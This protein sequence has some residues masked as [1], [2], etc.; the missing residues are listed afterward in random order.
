MAENFYRRFRRLREEC[1]D[2][3]GN[4][5]IVEE[6]H[7]YR[8]DIDIG[9]RRFAFQA[10]PQEDRVLVGEE[11]GN[12]GVEWFEELV[13]D[14]VYPGWRTSDRTAWELAATLAERPRR[15]AVVAGVSETAQRLSRVAETLA[16]AALAWRGVRYV[17]RRASHPRE[18]GRMLRNRARSLR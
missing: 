11:I 8:F 10:L 2:A 7:E 18:T 17:A 1:R 12:R 13:W 9:D 15:R 6:A 3:I 4:E 5:G 14:E 16:Y